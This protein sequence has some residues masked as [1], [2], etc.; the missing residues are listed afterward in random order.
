LIESSIRN[1]EYDQALERSKAALKR[2]P[3][4]FR[5]WSL[6]GIVYSLQGSDAEGLRGYGLVHEALRRCWL[7]AGS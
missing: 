6:E 2:A 1:H 4:D 3:N 7:A 5:L